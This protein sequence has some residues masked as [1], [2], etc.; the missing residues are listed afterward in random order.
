LQ[1]YWRFFFCITI[2]FFNWAIWLKEGA[3]LLE[4]AVSWKVLSGGFAPN[5]FHLLSTTFDL[6]FGSVPVDFGGH[7]QG[8]RSISLLQPIES[9]G[10]REGYQVC[11]IVLDGQS[12]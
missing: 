12:A 2:L 6:Q 8:G 9:Y 4:E 7:L 10:G 3:P 11:N 5:F 1:K